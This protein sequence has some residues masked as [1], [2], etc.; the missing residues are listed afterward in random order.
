MNL[1]HESSP[2]P[3]AKMELP[4]RT[5][6]TILDSFYFGAAKIMEV[7]PIQSMSLVSPSWKGR[8]FE[9]NEESCCVRACFLRAHTHTHTHTHTLHEKLK[10]CLKKAPLASCREGP[11]SPVKCS[12]QPKKY[13][14]RK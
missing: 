12:E 4:P 11:F 7:D 8:A 10:M 6:K 14:S 5:C 13:A 1:H 2:G 9:R 3:A